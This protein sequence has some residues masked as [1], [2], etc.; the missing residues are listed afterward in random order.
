[1]EEPFDDNFTTKKLVVPLPTTT[2]TTAKK[3]EPTKPPPRKK[4]IVQNEHWT[5]TADTYS[6]QESQLGLLYNLQ[7]DNPPLNVCE[8]I[9]RSHLKTKQSG[10]RSQDTIKGIYDETRFIRVEDIIQL[11]IDSQLVCFYCK[12]WTALFYENVRDPRQWSLERISNDDGHNRGN[13]VI[14]CLDCN[15]RRRTMYQDR[16]IATKQLRVNKLL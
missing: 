5:M 14:A 13:L 6:T 3:E 4:V 12:K 16:Y 15:M 2:T 10:Y 7:S 9:L 1:M 8:N 11:L